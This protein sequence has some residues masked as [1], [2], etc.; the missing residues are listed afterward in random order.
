M[1]GMIADMCGMITIV[2]L[3]GVLLFVGLGLMPTNS[4]LGAICLLLGIAVIIVCLKSVT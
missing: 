1:P 3:A 2:L 4:Q